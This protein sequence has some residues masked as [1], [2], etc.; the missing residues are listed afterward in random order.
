M[1]TIETLSNR[2]L[3]G[4]AFVS[5]ESFVVVDASGAPVI[6][7]TF[8]TREEAQAVIDG[9]GNLSEGLAFA[10]ATAPE[11]SAKGQRAMANVVADYLNWVAAGKPE[12]EVKEE[13]P[14]V[15]A[16]EEAAGEVVEQATALSEEEEF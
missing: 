13:A 15:E 1:F 5:V 8:D 3:K 16:S 10:A 2:V 14:A 4:S 12:A 6:A 11:K 7:K 9:M